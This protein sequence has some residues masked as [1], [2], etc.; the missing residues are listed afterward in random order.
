MIQILSSQVLDIRKE[1]IHCILKH[2]K[3][4][5]HF[6]TVTALKH[7]CLFATYNNMTTL[8]NI[9]YQKHLKQTYF[10]HFNSWK[11]AIRAAL[12]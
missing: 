10:L 1:Y 6:Y 5:E 9:F 12:L 11:D 4:T 3:H 7:C 8:W 2:L